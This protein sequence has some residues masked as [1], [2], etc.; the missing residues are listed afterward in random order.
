[1]QT[2]EYQNEYRIPISG[3]G[4]I[5]TPAAQYDYD[6]T[7]GMFTD[8]GGTYQGI[9][10]EYDPDNYYIPL[11]TTIYTSNEVVQQ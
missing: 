9:I 4:T 10:Y 5:I 3:T 11:N 6:I 1:M 2:D 8:T 7:G